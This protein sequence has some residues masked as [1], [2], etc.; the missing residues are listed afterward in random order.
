MAD[1]T[2]HGATKV[3]RNL[4]LRTR[5]MEKGKISNTREG[6]MMD[7]KLW[8][9]TIKSFVQ[10]LDASIARCGVIIKVLVQ[11]QKDIKKANDHLVTEVE[12]LK[13]NLAANKAKLAAK[14][15]D[16]E[17]KMKSIGCVNNSGELL[18]AIFTLGIACAFDSPT[19]KKFLNVKADIQEEAAIMNALAKR[20]FYFD[21]LVGS[22][23][24]LVTESAGM[25][26]T[27]RDFEQ[28]LKVSRG[29]LVSDFT[30]SDIEE[31]LGDCDFAN[32]FAESLKENLDN[33]RK[34]CKKTK[35]DCI[36]RKHRL[37]DAL[38][39]LRKDMGETAPAAPPAVKQMMEEEQDLV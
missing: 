18:R 35:N 30:P 19:K 13:K 34:V 38:I 24:T 32:D 31:N 5:L 1:S 6:L 17:K 14:L 28:G 37:D 8:D 16:L 12:Q 9:K 21:E 26:K 3:E 22:A 36:A 25:L 7:V 15:A 23:H 20:M 4:G 2:E 39:G 11:L 27:T 29:E 10:E 33:L